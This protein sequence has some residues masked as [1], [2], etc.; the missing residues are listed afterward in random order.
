MKVAIQNDGDF[1]DVILL[2]YSEDFISLIVELLSEFWACKYET[3]MK[4]YALYSCMSVCVSIIKLKTAYDWENVRF[5]V[6][7]TPFLCRL[8]ISLYL[9]SFKT[10]IWRVKYHPIYCLNGAQIRG[11]KTGEE[12]RRHNGRKIGV[13]QALL[14][15]NFN[16][17]VPVI[18]LN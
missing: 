12:L 14:S 15:L 18:K 11:R 2:Q 5:F 13:R 4:V 6:V 3:G 9:D 1:V 7:P 10:V 17:A 8:V 16:R